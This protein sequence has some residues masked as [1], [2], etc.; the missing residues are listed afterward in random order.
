MILVRDRSG[1]EYTVV[2]HERFQINGAVYTVETHWVANGR[3]LSEIERAELT[4]VRELASPLD[5]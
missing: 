2:E 5:A 1:N 4:I 3:E